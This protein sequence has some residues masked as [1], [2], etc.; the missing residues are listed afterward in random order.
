VLVVINHQINLLSVSLSLHNKEEAIR[1]RE[2]ELARQ[3]IQER[4]AERERIESRPEHSS[5]SLVFSL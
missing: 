5:L 3:G 1:D 4:Q 2:R